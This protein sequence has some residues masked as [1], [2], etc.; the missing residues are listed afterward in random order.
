[1]PNSFKKNNKMIKGKTADILITIYL[2]STLLIRIILEP[3][4]ES[5]PIISV[6]LGLVFILFIMA[7]IK[8][9]I[10]KPNYFG[11]L[12]KKT[13]KDISDEHQFI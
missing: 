9:N 12:K 1:M 8:V 10:L 5:H 6:A 11:L 3:A 7:L 2:L 4:L 13:T